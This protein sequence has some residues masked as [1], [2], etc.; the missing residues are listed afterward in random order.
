V[1]SDG[2]GDSYT[3]GQTFTMGSANV[4]LYA[5]WTSNP[6]YTVTYD[7]NGN[8]SGSVPT[9]S[10]HYEE[11]ATVTVLGNTGDLA[12]DGYT[13]AGWCVNSDGTGDSYTQG[14]TFTMG[15]ANVTLYAKWTP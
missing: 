7:G 13:F 2:T 6:T 4:T 1:N 14:Q 10:T 15:S 9:D 12:R 8:T 11:G 5:K 3:Q